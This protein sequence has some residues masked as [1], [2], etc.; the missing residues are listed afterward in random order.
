MWAGAPVLSSRDLPNDMWVLTQ[1]HMGN[2]R[3][4]LGAR[5]RCLAGDR[6]SSEIPLLDPM[7]AGAVRDAPRSEAAGGWGSFSSL[8]VVSVHTAL[9]SSLP[10]WWEVWESFSPLQPMRLSAAEATT[11]HCRGLGVIQYVGTSSLRGVGST[12]GRVWAA[13]LRQ[14][15]ADPWCFL[16]GSQEALRGRPGLEHH[17]R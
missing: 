12:V 1:N 16:L 8:V 9:Q 11:R 14:S 17:P 2:L 5:P 13:S 4:C 6:W 3:L 7:S 10:P 15:R